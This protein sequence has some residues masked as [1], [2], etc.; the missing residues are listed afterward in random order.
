MFVRDQLRRLP[1]ALEH[2]EEVIY[3]ATGAYRRRSSLVVATDRRLLLVGEQEQEFEEFRYDAIVS[4]KVGKRR[5]ER[6][7]L[8]ITTERGQTEIDEVTE[9]AQAITELIA[10]YSSSWFVGEPPA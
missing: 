3:L 10:P 2:S 4:A 9:N 5:F 6:P 8:R 7:H 1:A